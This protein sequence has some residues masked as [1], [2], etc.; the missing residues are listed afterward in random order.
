MGSFSNNDK[1]SGAVKLT[2][3]FTKDN[4]QENFIKILIFLLPLFAVLGNR[5]KLG[6]LLGYKLVILFLLVATIL[7]PKNKMWLTGQIRTIGKNNFRFPRF[8]I[9]TYVAAFWCSIFSLVSLASILFS[10]IKRNYVHLIGVW[11]II[12]LAWVLARLTKRGWVILARGW[13]FSFLVTSS[14][15]IWEI[16]TD[17]HLSGYMAKSK[18]ARTETD[19]GIASTF[20]NPNMY[21]FYL[22]F[23]ILVMI[24][25]FLYEKGIFSKLYLAGVGFSYPLLF[26]S[27]S[28]ACVFCSILILVALCLMCKKTRRISFVVVLF[29]L[30]VLVVVGLYTGKIQ[31]EFNEIINMWKTV[32]LKRKAYS[33]LSEPLRLG[34]IVNGALMMMRYPLTGMGPGTFESAILTE[35]KLVN[36]L[37]LTNPHFGFMEIGSE[38]GLIVLVLVIV[39]LVYLLIKGIRVFRIGGPKKWFAAIVVIGVFSVVILQLANSTLVGPSVISLALSIFAATSSKLSVSDRH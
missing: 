2:E 19:L 22:V 14:I 3:K 13:L 32:A 35:P 6:P 8:S 5:V 4:I 24:T 33:D 17:K 7:F 38:Y 27:Y 21:G 1:L 36:V 10:S 15:A 37:G 16:L 29:S 20:I 34:L 12:L 28:R 18:F 30:L 26:L 9:A 23:G 11:L 31:G 39:S 25:A